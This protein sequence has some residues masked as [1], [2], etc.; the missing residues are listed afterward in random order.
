MQSVPILPGGR[1]KRDGGYCI[2]VIT[3]TK[4][5]SEQEKNTERANVRVEM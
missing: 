2:L 5:I 1:E 3:Q 4:V